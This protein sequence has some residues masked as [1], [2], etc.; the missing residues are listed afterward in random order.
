MGRLFGTDGAR[1]VAN[2]EL[3]CEI[4]MS[5]GRAAALVLAENAN[6]RP[7]VII[8]KDTRTSSDMLEA[9]LCAGL[10]S[11]GA[12]AC[13]LGVVPTPAVAYLVRE[14]KADAGIM[15]SASHNPHEYNG[16]KLFSESGYKLSDEI[17]ERIESIVLDGAVDIS[18]PTGGEVG[19]IRRCESAADD[20][21]RHLLS[22]TNVSLRGMKLVVDC[23]NGSASA[24]AKQLFSALEA[25]CDFIHCS[26]NGTNINENCGSTHLDQ[27]AEHV[28]KHKYFAGITFDGDADRFLAVDENGTQIDGDKIIAALADDLNRKGK[29]P[30]NTAVVTVMSNLGFFRCCEENGI[31]TARTKVG[32]RYVLEEMLRGGYAIGGEQSGHIIMTEWGTTGDG[33]LTAIQLLAVCRERGHKLSRVVSIMQRYPQV[34]TNVR[35]DAEQKQRFQQNE[36][37]AA[38]IEQ[39]NRD[40]GNDGR[41][42]VRVSGTE[43]LIRIMVEGKDFDQINRIAVDLS[44]AVQKAVTDTV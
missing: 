37:L 12:D 44:E 11:V 16:I 19:R 4:A 18:F 41:V 26:P 43:P 32:D 7:V 22:T 34:L 42:L 21:V 10:C 5:I 2:K 1:G 13:L 25:D 20:Y 8:G 14:Y 39:I 17:E 3:T 28:K 23:A 35:A 6:H 30:H 38:Q 27:L 33:Q 29:L 31:Q 40:F 9:A 24:T 15:I 36:Q